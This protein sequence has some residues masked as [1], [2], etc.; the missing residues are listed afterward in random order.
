MPEIVI[1][2][3]SW[4]PYCDRAK[5]LLRA[6]GQTW[7]EID[8][9][10]SPAKCEEMIARSQRRTVPQIFI[11]ETH[12]GGSDELHALERQGKLDPLLVR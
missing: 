2:S 3:K 4:C 12:V 1:Y 9:E 11:G 6:K 7:T 8:V 5:D 10:A